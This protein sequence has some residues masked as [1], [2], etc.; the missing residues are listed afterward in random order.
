MR[1]G[2]DECKQNG[3]KQQIGRKAKKDACETDTSS[4]R[5]HS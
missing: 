3:R 1:K 4:K 5:V 2:G